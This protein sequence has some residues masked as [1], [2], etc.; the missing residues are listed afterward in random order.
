MVTDPTTPRPT[1]ALT[2]YASLPAPDRGA[3]LELRV[4]APPAGTALPVIVLAHGFGADRD[5]YGPLVDHWVGEGFVVVQPT[6][7]DS[8]TLGVDPTDPRYP[9]IWRTRVDDLERVMDALETVLASVSGLPERAD[10]ARLAVAGHSWGAQSVSMLLGARVLDAGG[11]PGPDRTDERVRAG[12]LLSI[13]GTGG[14]D[15][16][17]FAQEHFGFMNPD[18]SELRTPSLVVAGDADVSPLSTRGPD[19]FTDAH[20]LAPG[21]RQLVVVPGGEHSLGG[22]EDDDAAGADDANADRIDLVRRT[23]TAFLRTVL[24]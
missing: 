10:V 16:T 17:D 19:W 7:L 15:L 2:G 9:N 22:I 20:R 24:G 11:Q 13:P 18:F 8:A 1:T 21:V 12:V 3:D 4:C 5:A 23:T 14:A 6:F